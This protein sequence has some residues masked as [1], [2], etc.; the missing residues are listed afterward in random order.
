[1]LL[2]DKLVRE[3]PRVKQLAHPVTT[4]SL[5]N[6]PSRTHAFSRSCRHCGSSMPV[7]TA[8]DQLLADYLDYMRRNAGS[9]PDERAPHLAAHQEYCTRR[10][11]PEVAAD[12]LWQRWLRHYLTFGRG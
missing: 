1:M 12:R 8:G 3:R 5:A 10:N 4:G 2:P 7:R 9:S 6:T 11:L